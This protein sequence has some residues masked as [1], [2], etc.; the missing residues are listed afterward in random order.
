MTTPTMPAPS[1]RTRYKVLPL[2]LIPVLLLSLHQPGPTGEGYKSVPYRLQGEHYW[3]VCAGITGPQ[4]DGHHIYSDAECNRL[5]MDYAIGLGAAMS[6]C[7]TGDGLSWNEWLAYA[8][9]AWN[10][11]AAGFCK[12][13]AVRLI[14]S[15][16]H[17]A[18]CRA[19][20]H[21]FRASGRDCRIRANNC[22]GVIVRRQWEI[23]TCSG[24]A[25]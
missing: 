15:D 6:R 13:D 16:H 11:G 5:E 2:A 17:V 4:V 22:H 8:H 23:D 3:T 24:G 14:N 9:F 20:D 18:A 12:A 1:V 21:Y 7:L 19:L 25:W 10:T